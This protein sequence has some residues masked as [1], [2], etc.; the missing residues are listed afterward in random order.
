VSE[1]VFPLDVP[2]ELELLSLLDV[3]DDV[4]PSFAIFIPIADRALN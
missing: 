1:L 2:V 3:P 4:L